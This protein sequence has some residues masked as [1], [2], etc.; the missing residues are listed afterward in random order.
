MNSADRYKCFVVPEGTKKVS[1]GKDTKLPS[2]Y[3]GKITQL[4]RSFLGVRSVCVIVQLHVLIVVLLAYFVL[5][6]AV[7]KPSSSALR[8][9]PS[10][11]ITPTHVPNLE[12]EADEIQ[13]RLTLLIEFSN[14]FQKSIV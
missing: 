13:K 2:Q 4:G 10:L 3:R 11:L 9:P 8:R 12:L 14:K 1:Y 6:R 5:T 7:L